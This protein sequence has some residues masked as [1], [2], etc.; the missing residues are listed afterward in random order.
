MITFAE[1]LVGLILG[2]MLSQII[3]TPT[4]IENYV[5]ACS[6]KLVDLW[7]RLLGEND[8]E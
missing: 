2:L 6:D 8:E 5:R 4:R 1:I 3:A 7:F